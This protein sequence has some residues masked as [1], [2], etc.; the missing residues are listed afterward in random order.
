LTLGKKK[1]RG[2]LGA[3]RGKSRKTE[4]IQI[5]VIWDWRRAPPLIGKTK[6]FL[7]LTLIAQLKPKIKL[8]P[9]SWEKKGEGARYSPLRQL[10]PEGFSL[11]LTVKKTTGPDPK[12]VNVGVPLGWEFN[13]ADKEKGK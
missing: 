4:N 7:Q 12:R 5:D 9:D 2:K 6:L 1:R 11:C 3:E 13:M 8:E 10:L